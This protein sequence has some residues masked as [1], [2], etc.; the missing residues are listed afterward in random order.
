V[1]VPGFRAGDYSL[2]VL[3]GWLSRIGYQPHGS[4]ML[5]NVECMDSALDKLERRVAATRTQSGRRVALVGHSRGGHFAKAPLG[6][7]ARVQLPI[8]RS[9]FPTV[10][11]GPIA[12][13]LK[14]LSGGLDTR[15]TDAYPPPGTSGTPE[16]QPAV[17][18]PL[19]PDPPYASQH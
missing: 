5:A 10:F 18:P 2:S 4:G 17:I 16:P 19:V 3:S 15:G 11:S 14:N 8:S 9:N 12:A 13:I 7:L 6:H 1:L